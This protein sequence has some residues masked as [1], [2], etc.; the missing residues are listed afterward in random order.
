M[1]FFNNFPYTN[2]HELN[3]DWICNEIFKVISKVDEND[4]NFEKLVEYVKNYFDSISVPE[5]VRKVIDEMYADGRLAAI[6]A[7]YTP[8]K[9]PEM[10][11]DIEQIETTRSFIQSIEKSGIGYKNPEKT[12]PLKPTVYESVS[13]NQNV[14]D[15]RGSSNGGVN[16]LFVGSE[17][18]PRLLNDPVFW[19]R[20]HVK[21]NS[22]GDFNA[23]SFGAGLFETIT[24]GSNTS[25]PNFGGSVG[26]SSIAYAKSKNLGTVENQMWDFK[27]VNI[28]L[29][30]QAQTDGYNG[31]VT[32]GIWSNTASA[33][34]TENEFNNLPSSEAFVT[35]GEEINVWIRHKDV[36]YKEFLTGH[37]CSIGLFLNNYQNYEEGELVRPKNLNFAIDIDGTPCDGDYT[38]ADIDNWNG[39]YVGIRLDKIKKYG[40]LF[41]GY[42][43]DG[44]ECV[45]FPDSYAQYAHR[46]LSAI[47][48]GDNVLNMGHYYGATSKD[49]DML[50]SGNT[51]FYNINGA[52][53]TMLMT[54]SVTGETG[55][56][57]D[58]CV[59]I[60]VGGEKIKLLGVYAG[61]V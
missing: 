41:G 42:V 61:G 31:M 29:L 51:L 27:G 16:L 55:L 52:L 22:V 48:I 3:L 13:V 2:F 4:K 32:C 26:L 30:G 20:K 11:G 39:H 24:H 8:Y 45:K 25:D 6:I 54:K 57:A 38:S 59:E 40:I 1:G 12:Y 53:N 7:E 18:Q 28:G 46:P 19:V 50:R 36:G 35:I 10:F 43:S 56:T 47:N 37:G 15:F 14:T 17:E 9:T 44:V 34:L 21:F 58:R 49:S 33:K 5:E 23:H 60:V